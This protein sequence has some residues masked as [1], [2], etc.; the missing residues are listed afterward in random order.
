MLL[1][2]QGMHNTFAE[3]V[4]ECVLCV[5]S[6]ADVERLVREKPEVVLRFVKAMGNGLTGGEYWLQ[7]GV[8]NR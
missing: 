8:F 1:V 6:R 2:G 7:E 3:L 5:M 4:D